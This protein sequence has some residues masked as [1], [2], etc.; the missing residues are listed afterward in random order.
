VAELTER[1]LRNDVLKY[2]INMSH[3]ALLATFIEQI[4]RGRRTTMS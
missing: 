3:I 1:R 4:Q 2:D